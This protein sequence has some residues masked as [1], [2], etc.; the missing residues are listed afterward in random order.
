MTLAPLGRFGRDSWFQG[1]RSGF[2]AWRRTRPFWGGLWCILGGVIIAY[3][4]TTAIKIILISGTI[5]W[6]GILVGLLVVVMGLFLWFAPHLRQLVGVMA[7]AFSMVSLI[8][9]DYG[10]FFIGLLLG[11]IGGALGFAWTP[12]Q[13]KKT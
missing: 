8:T 11:T 12:I 5:V 1:L 2:R 9:S 13:P 6:L 7:V 3:G 4:P 10:G